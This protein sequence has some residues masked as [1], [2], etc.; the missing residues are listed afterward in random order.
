MLAFDTP[1]RLRRTPPSLRA[2]E[3]NFNSLKRSLGEYPEE[4]RGCVRMLA[5]I[6]MERQNA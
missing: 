4:G 5:R 2:W 1:S 3:V 6:G